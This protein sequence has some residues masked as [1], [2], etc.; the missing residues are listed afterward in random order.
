MFADVF[1]SIHR[2]VNLNAEREIKQAEIML[3]NQRILEK[4]SENDNP[5]N[6]FFSMKERGSMHLMYHSMIR[7]VKDY[8]CFIN[9]SAAKYVP[10]K[11]DTLQSK[12]LR[13]YCG[14]CKTSPVLV[15]LIQIGETPSW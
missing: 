13:L 6:L 9:G 14:T 11:L 4:I 3:T 10:G 5:F 2:S 15:L 1:Q 8:G 7:S 12:T